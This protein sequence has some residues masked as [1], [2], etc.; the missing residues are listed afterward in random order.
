MSDHA[1]G[2]ASRDSHGHTHDHSHDHTH[3]HEADHGPDGSPVDVPDE[4]ALRALL[5]AEGAP[6]ADGDPAF[7]SP[8]Q[9]RAFGLAVAMRGEGGPVDWQ[10][11]Q[12]RLAAEVEASPGPD[13]P[14]TLE[15][16]YYRQWLAALERLLVD[17]GYL[18]GER[19]RRRAAEFADGDRTAAEFVEG[20]HEH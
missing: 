1:E 16:E 9:A 18:T 15:D 3:D 20:H 8:W 19:L 7:A 2:H 14:E 13:D 11:F 10:S 17:E 12:E 4:G 6:N 5:E